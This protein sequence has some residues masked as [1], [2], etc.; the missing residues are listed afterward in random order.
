MQLS[1]RTPKIH[2]LH[3]KGIVGFYL[4]RRGEDSN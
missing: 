3:K 4:K 1:H 2:A